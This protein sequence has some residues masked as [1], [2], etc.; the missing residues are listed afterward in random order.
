MV[1]NGR[2]LDKLARAVQRET[3]GVHPLKSFVIDVFGTPV[4]EQRLMGSWVKKVFSGS[5][6][7]YW[8]RGRFWLSL[9][10]Q[11]VVFLSSGRVLGP[12]LV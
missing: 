1:R 7:G 11:P 6:K 2:I 9:Q 12:F 10:V 8:N 5:R 4:T 3:D